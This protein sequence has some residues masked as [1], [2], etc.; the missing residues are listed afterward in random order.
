MTQLTFS[1]YDLLCLEGIA[2]ALL[3]F[4]GKLAAP[5]YSLTTTSEISIYARNNLL[6]LT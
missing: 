3:V 1:R 4:Q 2:R 5:K 6:K